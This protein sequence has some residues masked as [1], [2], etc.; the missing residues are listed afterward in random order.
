MTAQ[1]EGIA[2][3]HTYCLADEK[4]ENEAQNEFSYMGLFKNL[5]NVLP[6]AGE[7]T[8]EAWAMKTTPLMLRRQKIRSG[9]HRAPAACRP[10]YAARL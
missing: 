3:M 10:T 6:F 4:P 7:P 9:A 5:N 1:Q 2:Q 8:S